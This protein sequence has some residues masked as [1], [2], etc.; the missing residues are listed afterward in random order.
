METSDR[1]SNLKKHIFY[2]LLN[3][4]G[5]VFILVRYA[6]TVIL[7]KRGFTDDEKD[8]GIILVF[9]SRMNFTWDDYG[10]TVT[11]VFGTSPE[12]C[13]VPV[14]HIT[15]VYSPE[16]GV[17]FVS[18]PQKQI[19]QG[20]LKAA[21]TAGEGSRESGGAPEKTHGNVVRVDFSKKKK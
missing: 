2:E 9:N 1:V 13:Y 17:Q 6:D 19:S 7:G 20:P 14:E 18:A 11:L 3:G 5:R 15:A 10:I 8:N 4:A 16:L 21:D 12:K